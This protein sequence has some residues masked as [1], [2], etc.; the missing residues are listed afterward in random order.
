MDDHRAGTPQR[1]FQSGKV[2]LKFRERKRGRDVTQI[3][4]QGVWR[5]GR[6]SRST[7]Q[8]GRAGGLLHIRLRRSDAHMQRSQKLVLKL[9]FKAKSFN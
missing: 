6:A 9:H 1:Q 4:T 3:K 2:D 5:K 8:S 7:D